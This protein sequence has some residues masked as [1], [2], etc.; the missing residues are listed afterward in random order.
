MT[1]RNPSPSRRARILVL[2]GPGL[3]LLATILSLAARIGLRPLGAVWVCAA[4]WSLLTAFSCVLWRGFRRGDWSA[5]HRYELPDGR[6]EDFEWSARTG[7]Y[8]WRRDLEE[9][10]LF[11]QDPDIPF[12]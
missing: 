1:N 5:F 12:P 9:Q 4:L 2:A 11:G 7:R 3:A 10:E 8:A 6:E